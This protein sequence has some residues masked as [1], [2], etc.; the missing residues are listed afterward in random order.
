M[1]FNRRFFLKILGA[2]GLSVAAGRK[3]THAWESKAPDDPYGCLVDLT[4][5]VGC[6]KCEEACN[7][8]N[9]L[10]GPARP[11]DDLTLLDRK[12]RPDENAYT[13]VNRYY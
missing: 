4:R 13:V 5:C 12:R 9:H 1:K 8:V 6:R 11:F 2:T 10:P 7:E 3:R